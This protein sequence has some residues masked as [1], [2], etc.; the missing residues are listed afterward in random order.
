MHSPPHHFGRFVINDA[1]PAA[2]ARAS[3][4]TYNLSSVYL[5]AVTSGSG[6]MP[7]ALKPIC[8]SDVPRRYNSE[9]SLISNVPRRYNSVASLISLVST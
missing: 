7:C 5:V 9:A 1:T 8:V 6:Q 2:S 4:R 3:R